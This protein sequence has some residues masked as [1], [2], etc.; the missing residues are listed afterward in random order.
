M[1]QGTG[2][3]SSSGGKVEP[4][5]NAINPEAAAEI[6]RQVVHTVPVPLNAGRGY[7]APAPVATTSHRS[8]SQGKR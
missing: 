1:K 4:R 8:G 3:S 7:Q 6:G 5:S 2:N